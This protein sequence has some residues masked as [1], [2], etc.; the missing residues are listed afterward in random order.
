MFKKIFLGLLFIFQINNL[1]F[2]SNNTTAQTVCPGNTSLYCHLNPTDLARGEHNI[3]YSCMSANQVGNDNNVHYPVVDGLCPLEP[4]SVNIYIGGF[5]DGLYVCGIDI[6]GHLCELDDANTN[7]DFLVV[8]GN[9]VGKSYTWDA[10]LLTE[11]GNLDLGKTTQLHLNS[12]R[13]GTIYRVKY[14]YDYERVISGTDLTVNQTGFLTGNFK[15]TVANSSTAGNYV[16]LADVKAELSYECEDRLGPVT[17]QEFPEVFYPFNENTTNELS[18]FAEFNLN[19]NGTGKCWFEAK[20]T[21]G[22]VGKIRPINRATNSN[23][24][25]T[26]K[27]QTSLDL[28]M[29][30]IQN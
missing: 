28:K 29:D 12:F 22:N 16:T 18:I 25:T 14:C 10:P 21:E 2:A 20:F 1:S 26:G 4:P 8:D 19:N 30:L 15:A 17:F 27:I 3:E 11:E 7:A 9:N 13:F 6:L 5:E 24:I 23:G